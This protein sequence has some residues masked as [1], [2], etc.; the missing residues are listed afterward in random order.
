MTHPRTG[1]PM[2]RLIHQLGTDSAYVIVG[3]PIALVGLI[4]TLPLFVLG[5]GTIVTVVGFPLIA[6]A[7]F[8]ARR[9]AD[10]ARL[11]LRAVTREPSP[12]PAYRSAPAG[13]G[14]WRRIFAPLRD[15]QSW[16]DLIH[17]VFGWILSTISFVFTIAWWAVALGGITS[18]IWERYIPNPTDE[19]D[20]NHLLRISDTL[21]GRV[22]LYTVIGLFFMITLPL[23]VRVAALVPAHFGRALLTGIAE[24]QNRI[25]GLEQQQRDSA[26]AAEWTALH[27][28]QREIREGQQQALAG[29]PRTSDGHASS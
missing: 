16:L 4:A 26:V 14:F 20:L 8:A 7:L 6:G 2:T 3:F 5:V 27:R 12:R 17:A 18:V 25:S 19:H 29:L 9:I 23:V 13:S 1:S 21:S 22:G 24:V 28:L 15:V 10:L 11:R